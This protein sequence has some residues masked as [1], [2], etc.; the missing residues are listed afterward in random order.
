MREG[1]VGN[2]AFFGHLTT[3]SDIRKRTE[4][5]LARVYTLSRQGCL[6]AYHIQPG[7]IKILSDLRYISTDFDL[8]HKDLLYW[9]ISQ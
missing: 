6:A 2:T 9:A 4:Y 7:H 1:K 3:S 5:R 8:M